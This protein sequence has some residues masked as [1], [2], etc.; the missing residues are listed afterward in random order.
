MLVLPTPAAIEPV[1]LTEHMLV[2]T[3]PFAIEPSTAIE[4][5]H[6]SRVTQVWRSHSAMM[7]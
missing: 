1:H 5:L 7:K 3:T 6:T 2:L 4:P